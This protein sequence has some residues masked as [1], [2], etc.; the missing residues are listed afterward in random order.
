MDTVVRTKLFIVDDSAP[1]RALLA[2]MVGHVPDVTIVGE[3]DSPQ[4][5]I[6]GIRE[7]LPDVVILDLHL[8]GGSGIEVLRAI[9]PEAPHIAFIVLTNHPTAQYRRVC[10]AAGASYFLDKSNEFLRI[11]ELIRSGRSQTNGEAIAIQP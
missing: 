10:V 11:N 3:A 8:T 5:A 6:R 2:E 4:D 9:H 1:I 7:T